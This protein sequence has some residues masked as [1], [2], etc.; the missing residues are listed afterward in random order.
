[1]RPPAFSTYSSPPHPTPP[2][3]NKRSSQPPK[4]V[5]LWVPVPRLAALV[6]VRIARLPRREIE[7]PSLLPSAAE[8]VPLGCLASPV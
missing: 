5:L 2:R 4:V 1:M 3:R 8:E 7:G 6:L